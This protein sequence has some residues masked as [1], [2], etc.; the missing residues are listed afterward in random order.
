MATNILYNQFI[1][2]KYIKPAGSQKWH[3]ISPGLIPEEEWPDIL[4]RP[5][6]C[7]RET[8]LQSLQ[9]KLIH[10]II[11]CNKKTFWYEIERNTNVF[12]LRWNRRYTSFLR[13]LWQREWY[14][15][16]I[17]YLVEPTWCFRCGLSNAQQWK[18]YFIWVAQ[19]N[20]EPDYIKFL[21]STHE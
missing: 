6:R 19:G 11:N 9:F 4:K 8:K 3:S 7:E 14:M 18:R 2:N 5:Y 1:K 16:I 15:E 17:F 13:T 12:I 21:Y 20:W 10:R